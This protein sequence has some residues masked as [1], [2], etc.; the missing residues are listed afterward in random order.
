[1]ALKRT[2]NTITISGQVTESAVNTFTQAQIDLQLNPLD[3][4]CFI[5]ESVDMDLGAGASAQAGV[6]TALAASLSNTSRTTIGNLNNTNCFARIS[7][8]IKSAGFV[9]GGVGFQSVSPDS[10]TAASLDHVAILATDNLFA[11]V[12]GTANAAAD[13]GVFSFKIYGYRAKADAATYAALVQSELL[14]S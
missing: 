1:M 9:D 10:P 5:V 7:Q 14:S 12:D 8:V 2:S 6:N 3:N 11:Q 4:E 13:I